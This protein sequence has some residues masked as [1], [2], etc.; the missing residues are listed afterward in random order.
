VAAL[1]MWDASASL[2]IQGFRCTLW[3]VRALEINRA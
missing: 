2:A 1:Q 3:R